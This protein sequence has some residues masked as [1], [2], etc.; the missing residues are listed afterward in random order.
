MFQSVEMFVFG[1]L[2][3]VLTHWEV[4]KR[5]VND[6]NFKNKLVTFRCGFPV[7]HGISSKLYIFHVTKLHEPD[8]TNFTQE[9][10]CNAN[11]NNNKL[12]YKK[13]Y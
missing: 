12:F 9:I 1:Q 2:Y 13:L 7:N 5:L 8:D 6:D 4:G 10:I 11:N 3:N